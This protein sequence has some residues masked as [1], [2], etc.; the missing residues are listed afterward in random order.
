MIAAKRRRKEK[1]ISCLTY[2]H[3]TACGR[4]KI[5]I[6]YNIPFHLTSDKYKSDQ[7]EILEGREIN[8][9]YFHT[10]GFK[11]PI[12]C[13]NSSDLGK[14]NIFCYILESTK[15]ILFSKLINELNK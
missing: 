9:N 8:I 5:S 14:I 6:M 4:E 12:L 11:R 13:H 2:L 15:T 10:N 7:I 3:E 1:N